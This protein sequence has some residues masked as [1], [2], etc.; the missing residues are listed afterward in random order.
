MLSVF[1][2]LLQCIAEILTLHSIVQ[3]NWN[4]WQHRCSLIELQTWLLV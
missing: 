4:D 3:V 2:I 1:I